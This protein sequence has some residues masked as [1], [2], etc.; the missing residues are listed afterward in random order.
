MLS[1]VFVAGSDD[2]AKGYLSDGAAAAGVDAVVETTDL[3]S[4]ELDLLQSVLTEQPLKHVLREPGGGVIAYGGDQGPWVEDVRP[5]LTAALASLPADRKLDLPAGLLGVPGAD[6]AGDQVGQLAAVLVDQVADDLLQPALHLGLQRLVHAQPV[7]E[8]DDARLQPASQLRLRVGGCLGDRGLDLGAEPG[9]PL[10]DRRVGQQLVLHRLRPG[11]QLGLGAQPLG[12]LAQPQVVLPAQLVVRLGHQLVEELLQHGEA[13]VEDHVVQRLR[14]PPRR[15]LAEPVAQRDPVVVE[16]PDQPAQHR[17][18]QHLMVAAVH[19][20]LQSA[21]RDRGGRGLR[22]PAPHDLLDR[23]VDVLVP[24]HLTEAGQRVTRVLAQPGGVVRAYQPAADPAG[25][26]QAAQ[27]ANDHLAGQEVLLD[28]LAQALAQRVLLVRDDRGVRDGYPHR[29]PEQR[30]DREPVGQRAHH[31][32]LGGGPQVAHPGRRLR[33]QHGDEEDQRRG[34]EQAGGEQLGAPQLR[35]APLVRGRVAG[36]AEEGHVRTFFSY[37]SRRPVRV[38]FGSWNWIVSHSPM[39]IGARPPVAI[40][41]AVPPISASMRRTSPSIWPANPYRIPDCSAS[42][43]DLPITDRGRASSILNSRAPRA[44]SA[45][46]EISMP[47]ASAPPRNSPRSLTTSK[48]V[49]VP[50]STTTQ[51]PPYRW[52]AARELTIR[53]GPTS[54]GLSYSSGTPVRT[55]GSTITV[56]MSG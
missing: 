24:Q 33:D 55:P 31:G 8:A 14:H 10:P 5:A 42:M 23:G 39:T 9:R 7:A 19:R 41:D 26:V 16:E 12:Q 45:S 13:L 29:V 27:L 48:L 6:G 52:C 47:G 32:R 1:E 18:Q 21:C 56:G 25:H 43:V 38:R 35:P 46:T 15:L 3:T 51:A 17:L 50:K 2:E 4:M 40:T 11:R 37:T 53:S 54:L 20:D 22:D 36:D 49:E 44:A 34:A 28:E 30:G